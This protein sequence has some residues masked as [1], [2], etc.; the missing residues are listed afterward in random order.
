MSKINTT[1]VNIY[2]ILNSHN[3][4]SVQSAAIYAISVILSHANTSLAK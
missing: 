1:M 4:K 3:C 2:Y